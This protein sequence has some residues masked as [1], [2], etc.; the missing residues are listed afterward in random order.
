MSEFTK[1]PWSWIPS[2]FGSH[3]LIGSDKNIVCSDGSADGEYPPDIDVTGADA[4]LISA[5]PDL[6]EALVMARYHVSISGT[7]E[8][9]AKVEA[10]IAKA[11]GEQA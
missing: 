10:A 9:L 6:L 1:G 4:R 3:I 5:A 11:K 8:E 7:G 2:H